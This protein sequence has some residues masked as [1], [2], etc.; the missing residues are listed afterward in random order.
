[1]SE[2]I[3]LLKKVLE[4]CFYAED[5]DYGGYCP[6]CNLYYNDE[7]RDIEHYEECLYFEVVSKIAEELDSED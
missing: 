5:S 1:M 2:T 3:K 7:K 4:E 6:V